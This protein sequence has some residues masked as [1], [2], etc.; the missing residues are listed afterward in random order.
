MKEYNRTTRKWEDPTEAKARVGSLKKK[1]L[2]WGNR[3]HRFKLVV[4]RMSHLSD[5]QIDEYYKHKGRERDFY[6]AEHDKL[7]TL[8]IVKEKKYIYSLSSSLYR[9]E[10][11]RHFECEVCGKQNTIYD[12]SE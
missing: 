12:K 10:I 7:V 4:P 3:P 11:S 8:G 9:M 1:V 5:E 6:K 2:C